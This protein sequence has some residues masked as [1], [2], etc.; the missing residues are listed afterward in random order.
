MNECL[1]VLLCTLDDFSEIWRTVLQSVFRWG[2][3]F[4][5]YLIIAFK[6][7]L[8]LLAFKIENPGLICIAFLI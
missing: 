6:V 5:F 1:Y 7:P 2:S 8:F 4:H 3:N